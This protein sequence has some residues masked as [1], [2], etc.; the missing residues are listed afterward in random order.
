MSEAL[1]S[2]ARVPNIIA[3][4][5][6]ISVFGFF[7]GP[8]FAAVSHCHQIYHQQPL[9]S[10]QAMSV[11]SQLFTSETKSTA[12]SLVFVF[13]QMGGSVFPIVTGLL[14]TSIGVWVLQPI[15]VSLI[16][17]TTVCWFL[18]PKPKDSEND[19]LHRE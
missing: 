10:P 4:S 11:G 7:S 13:A 9:T 6:A 18:V 5:I 1:T 19:E 8:L 14:S 12:L 16:V 3:A 15:L 2:N 17:V